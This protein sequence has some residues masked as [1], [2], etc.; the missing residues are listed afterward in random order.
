M[1]QLKSLHPNFF[2]FGSVG[3]VT[4]DSLIRGWL[5]SWDSYMLLCLAVAPMNLHLNV[6]LGT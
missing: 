2:H 4:A 5:G 6:H 1:N 3:I